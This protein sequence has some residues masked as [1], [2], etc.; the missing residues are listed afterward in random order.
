MSK[1]KYLTNTWFISVLLFFVIIAC[2][3][4]SDAA[5]LPASTGK[6]S[7]SGGAFMRSS[8]ST[9]SK[10]VTGIPDHKKVT[11]YSEVFKSK[12]STA[13][14]NRW[15]YVQ[16]GSKKGYVRAD[17]V[18][19]ISSPQTTG[20]TT[21]WLNY[22]TGVGTG[23]KCKGTL[24]SGAKV[25]VLM[26]AKYSKSSDQWYKIKVGS[27]SYYVSA[28]YV[29]LGKTSS[30]SSSSSSGSSSSSKPTTGLSQTAK[31]LLSN[32][33]NGGSSCRVVA[34]F[35][36]S[37]CSKKFEVSGTGKAYTPQGMS[38]DGTNYTFVF[39]NTSK[40]AIIKY[41]GSGKKL[42]STYFPYNMG[43]PNGITYNPKT[44]LFYIF[45]GN[46]YSAYTY[47]Q[48]TGK[49]GKVST[50]YS[51]SG[52]AYDS[53]K[54]VMIASSRTGMREYSSDGKFSHRKLVYR[55]THSGTH[56]VQDC[57]AYNGIVFHGVSGS[58]KKTINYI[59]VYRM[60]D[61]KYLGSIKL[62]IGEIESMIVNNSGQ[63]E[64]LI[65]TSSHDYVWKT[66]LN[67]KELL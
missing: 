13:K 20:Y 67:V 37:N 44:G 42:K 46:Q 59:D 61:S 19:N 66:P 9:S 28:A 21:D 36:T 62:T 22:R 52:I 27:S 7:S 33:T 54:G 41:S 24:K 3:A 60:S 48:N 47:N 8:Y 18:S 26:P 35:S 51:S 2:S 11:I 12:T 58:N 25:T 53:A 16:Y 15:Y 32:P 5:S 50:P 39:G 6:I 38:F 57:C 34:T 45:K 64:L 29:K 40:Q 23:M 56:Y 43:H 1:Q 4:F 65:N 49:F 14:K 10:K 30:S 55:C 31:A 17:L 63:L